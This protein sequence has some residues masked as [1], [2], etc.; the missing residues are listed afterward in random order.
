MYVRRRTTT[1]DYETDWQ[2]IPNKYIKRWG[3]ISYSVEDEKPNFYKYSGMQISVVNNDG[4]FSDET[5]KRSFFYGYL[6]LHRTMVKIEAGYIDTDDT[7]YPTNSTLF[8][9]LIDIGNTKYQ[10]DNEISIR[11]NH[12]SQIFEEFPADRIPSL[13]SVQVA[14]TI[15]GKIRDYVDSSAV[16]IFQKF[17][18][19]TAWNITTTTKNYNMATSTSLQ[20][21]SC[22]DLMQKLAEAENYVVYIDPNA[23]FYFKANTGVP[24]SVT[25][26]FSGINDND[27]TWGHS[28]MRQINVDPGYEKIYNRI[29]VKYEDSD[30]ITSY[31]IYNEAW[32]WGDSSSSFRFGVREYKTENTWMAAS[33]ASD[34]AVALYAEFSEPKQRITFDSKFVP[35]VNILSRV[36]MTYQTNRVTEG[37]KWGLFYWNSGIWGRILSYNLN[38]NDDYKV[39]DIKHDIDTFK[40]TLKVKVI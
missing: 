34:V 30:T 7:E 2:Q 19:L 38:I 14:S 29:K 21:Q 39:V 31:Y 18:S 28:I 6:G 9:G 37:T 40:S 36:S 16:A 8:I 1:G 27:R 23:N 3:Q 12:I 24:A 26:H 35:Q 11:I 10:Q 17:I 33:T 25:F 22:W 32:T 5:Q 4:F 13:G 15:I 20:N